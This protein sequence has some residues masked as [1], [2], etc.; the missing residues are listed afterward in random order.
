MCHTG[1]Q[2]SEDRTEETTATTTSSAPRSAG[3][4]AA[5]AQS[6][7][8][9]SSYSRGMSR[10]DESFP[11]SSDQGRPLDAAIAAP[12]VA[13]TDL[14]VKNIIECELSGDEALQETVEE[15]GSATAVQFGGGPE[16]DIDSDDDLKA[17]LGEMREE[18]R[19]L[20]DLLASEA[21]TASSVYHEG[22]A[23]AMAPSVAFTVQ[24]P[25]FEREEEEEEEEVEE[26]EEESSYNHVV[27]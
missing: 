7:I 5:P 10:D 6:S 18:S 21:A 19:E 11:S 1:Q 13:K 12:A 8:D 15:R 9:S 25:S 3:E 20:V 24:P 17:D 22:A 4:A 14:V 26:E 23:A 27:L 2:I 16:K